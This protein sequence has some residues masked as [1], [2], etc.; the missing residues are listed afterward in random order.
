MCESATSRPKGK[1]AAKTSKKIKFGMSHVN[2]CVAYF[3]KVTFAGVIN[4]IGVWM[5]GICGRNGLDISTS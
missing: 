5:G 3:P 2:G 4:I 1:S